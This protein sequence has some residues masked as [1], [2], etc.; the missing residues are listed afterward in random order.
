[1]ATFRETPYAAFNFT[2]SIDGADAASV[3]AGF[4]EVRG[5]DRAVGVLRYRAGN[6]RTLQPQIVTGLGQPATVTLSRGVIGDLSLH[7]WISAALAGQPTARTVVVSLVSED[8]ADI[9]Q[10]WV[11]RG[12]VPVRL[13]GPALDALANE[14]AVE[15]LVLAVE[16][17]EAE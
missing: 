10:R 16:A 8:R 2:V 7:E 15:A 9:A 11:L 1:M 6:A 17:I 14:I 13:D 5:L 4:S 12:A 3:Q